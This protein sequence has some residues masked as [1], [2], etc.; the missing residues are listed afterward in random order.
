MRAVHLLRALFASGLLAASSLLG[1][2]AIAQ[3]RIALVIGNSNYVNVRPLANPENDASAMA[4]LF[5]EAKFDVVD[6]SNN[7]GGLEMRRLF[8]DFAEKSRSADIAVVYYAGHGIEID[9]INYLLPVDTALKRDIDVEDEAI[10]LD[11]IVRMLEPAKRLRLIILDAC[12]DNPFVKTVRRTSETRSIGRGLVRIEPPSS[13]TLIAYAAKERTTASDGDGK[14]SPFTT[15]LLKNLTVPGLDLRIALGRVRDDVMETTRNRQEP[16]VYGSLGGSTVSLVPEPAKV[17]A[18]ARDPNAD[19]RRDYEFAS[20]VGTREAWDSFLALHATGFYADL[21]RGQRAKLNVD[22]P[23]VA[24]RTA[25]AASNTP[26]NATAATPPAS[27]PESKAPVVA[28]TSATPPPDAAKPA[29]DPSETAKLMHVELQRLGCYP[30]AVDASW[31]PDSRRAMELFNKSAGANLE[32]KVAMLDTLDVL[33]AKPTRVCPL[34]CKSGYRSENDACVKIACRSG[35]VANEKGE[36]ER[37]RE[38]QPK[39]K[40]AS[41]PDREAKPAAT[42][43]QAGEAPPAQIVCGMTGCLPVKKGCKSQMVAAG[44]GEV[45]VVTCDK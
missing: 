31:G 7:L 14:H 20:Q 26:P 23:Q 38:R 32:T 45:A 17:A 36:C 40:T 9:G 29:T 21:A 11:R 39:A 22:T 15:A 41:R 12:R 19:A 35:F 4:A 37:D 10:S 24:T 28:M 27:P 44:R 42:R 33:R 1:S 8:R 6:A 5:R 2:E 16:F 18:P 13:D 34:E 25:P 3:K 30:G 43:R